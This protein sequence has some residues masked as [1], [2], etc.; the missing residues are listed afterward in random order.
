MKPNL[1]VLFIIP[2]F[3]FSCKDSQD[4]NRG[5]FQW[6][7]II[8]DTNRTWD[9][10]CDDKCQTCY[11]SNKAN[12]TFDSIFL[13]STT[14]YSVYS[15]CK[16]LPAVYTDNGNNGSSVTP[17]G[18]LEIDYGVCSYGSDD[19]HGLKTDDTCSYLSLEAGS[20]TGLRVYIPD[21]SIYNYVMFLIPSSAHGIISFS[22][23]GSFDTAWI[24]RGIT[25]ELSIYSHDS[26]TDKATIE[27]S[28]LGIFDSK[29]P[30]TLIG[31]A[32]GAEDRLKVV[33]YKKRII[34]SLYVYS[35][36]KP[37]FNPADSII[38]Q[39]FNGFSGLRQAVV[40]L[41]GVK[42][43]SITTINGDLNGNGC[44]DIFPNKDSVPI[45]WRNE[46]LA[47]IDSIEKDF[48]G[49]ASCRGSI[50]QAPKIFLLPS[51][52]NQDW[53][54][55]KDAAAGSDTIIVQYDTS[56]S[57]YLRNNLILS[58]WDGSDSETIQLNNMII[59][60]LLTDSA[61]N[62]M[63]FQLHNGPLKNYHAEQS[64]LVRSGHIEGLTYS[65]ISCSIMAGATNYH[66]M[67]HEF[68]HMATVGPLSH[69]LQD[70][71]NIMYPTNPPNG[72]KLRYRQLT[73]DNLLG[74]GTP[75]RQWDVLHNH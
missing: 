32:Y 71:T 21:T 31:H 19:W 61:N 28:A 67:I 52:I 24:G 15:K 53:I 17:T 29:A 9:I 13:N 2:I 6:K 16:S 70:T 5:Q 49:C 66:N 73:T 18:L 48:N 42:K 1:W 35:L 68:L 3:L 40:E 44:L 45:A 14:Y 56:L 50:V 60:P 8:N 64:I 12:S 20:Y 34:D 33:V 4:F 27:I 74:L 75:E 7:G 55:M 57:N 54:L 25:R 62:K 46:Y 39:N 38:K 30:D 36:N 41:K 72:N 43:D 51:T 65:G 63:A 22:S 26:T 37:S 58:N 10:R 23:A 47:I 69:T 11:A 59:D